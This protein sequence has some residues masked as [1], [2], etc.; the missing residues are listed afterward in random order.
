[1]SRSRRRE[2]V[3]GM[4]ANNKANKKAD[5]GFGRVN[6]FESWT[7]GCCKRVG[8]KRESVIKIDNLT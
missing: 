4:V 5:A 1:M 6:W 8:K 3:M 2:L 7:L